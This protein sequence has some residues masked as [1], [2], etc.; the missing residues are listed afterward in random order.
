MNLPNQTLF[1]QN[2]TEPL[3]CISPRIREIYLAFLPNVHVEWQQEK[4]A[5]VAFLKD[6]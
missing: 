3:H 2:V 5:K 1:P 4:Q 6:K